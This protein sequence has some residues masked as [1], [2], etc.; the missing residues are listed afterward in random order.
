MGIISLGST[1]FGH[2]SL[3]LETRNTISIQNLITEEMIYYCH[4]AVPQNPPIICNIDKDNLHYSETDLKKQ[5]MSTPFRKE[6]DESLY[7]RVKDGHV[8]TNL[9]P[10]IPEPSL[11]GEGDEDVAASCGSS[12][13]LLSTVS[14][15][16]NDIGMGPWGLR[17]AAPGIGASICQLFDTFSSFPK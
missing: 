3:S 5:R 9:L 2:F 11:T 14:D 16:L 4:T 10:Q 13:D 1:A 15:P 12:S 7:N 8:A 17:L 6:S